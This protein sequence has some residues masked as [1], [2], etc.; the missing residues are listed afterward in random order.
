MLKLLTIKTLVLCGRY[1]PTKLLS[2]ITE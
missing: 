2:T 1:T